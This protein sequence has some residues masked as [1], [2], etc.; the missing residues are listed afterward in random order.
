MASGFLTFS[1]FNTRMMKR[2]THRMPAMR[3]TAIHGRAMALSSGLKLVPEMPDAG[4][5]LSTSARKVSEL[6][7]PI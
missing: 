3:T 1:M 4:D 2:K 7:D 6:S 5:E